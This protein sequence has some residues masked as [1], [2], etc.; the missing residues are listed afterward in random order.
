MLNRLFE[1]GNRLHAGTL[2]GLAVTQ[3]A[4][5]AG[6]DGNDRGAQRLYEMGLVEGV[7][8]TV[9]RK[10]PM[11]DPIEVRVM[12]YSLSLRLAEAARIRVSS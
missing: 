12:G 7:E 11:G 6:I 4:R 10:A 5:V 9:V 2:A 1:R 8:V 3:R